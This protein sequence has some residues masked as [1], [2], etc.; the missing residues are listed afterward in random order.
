MT[1][2]ISAPVLMLHHVEPTPLVPPPLHPAS[3]LDRADFAG[4][5]DDLIARGYRTWT[6][7]EAA[8]R[9]RLPRR[10]VALT[11]DDGCRCFAEHAFPELQKRGM[12]AT[13]FAVSG[14][15]GG[16]NRWDRAAGEREEPLLDAAALR[17]LADGGI[18]IGSHS[19]SHRD[20]TASSDAELTAEVVGSRQD[21]EAALGR[22]VLTF[23]YPYGRLDARARAVVEA[24]GY[25]AA[26]GIHANSGARAGDPF[27]LP[28][29]IVNPG[30]S[31]FERRLKTNGL[32]PLW[33]RLPRLGLLRALRTGG[34][35][36]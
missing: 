28:R 17:R 9:G 8:K 34:G 25:L 26:V 22:P 21:L 12:T 14:E 33:S 3:Y 31:R 1:A 35:K 16:T 29:M 13:L 20:L 5:L 6:L 19:R 10:S 11:F 24:A 18:E 23:C 27:A 4:F 7:A 30:E 32:Y 15:L 36:R 2:T